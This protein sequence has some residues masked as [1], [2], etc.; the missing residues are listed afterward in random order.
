MRLVLVFVDIPVDRYG[1]AG[2]ISLAPLHRLGGS[3]RPRGMRGIYV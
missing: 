2:L 3:M 1:E